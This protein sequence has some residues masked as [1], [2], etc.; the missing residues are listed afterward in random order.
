MALT[1]ESAVNSL[2]AMFPKWDKEILGSILISNNGRVESTIE[3]VLAME[4]N[5]DTNNQN[6]TEVDGITSEE[7]TNES[8][9]MSESERPAATSQSQMPV[10][11][12]RTSYRGTRCSLPNDFLLMPNSSKPIPRILSDE[13]LAVMLQNE[14]FQRELANEGYTRQKST[15]EGRFWPDFGTRTAGQGSGSSSS[16]Q[17]ATMPDL[18]IM[19]SIASL[20]ETAKRNLSNI[21]LRFS[22]TDNTTSQSGSRHELKPLVSDNDDDEDEI[23]S[24]QDASPVGH[25]LNGYK[26][27]WTNNPVVEG[28]KKSDE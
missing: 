9:K 4:G 18:G 21:A 14:L 15:G 17:P 5:N 10:S 28:A 20:S 22:S 8:N 16:S 27:N 25:V 23:I 12:T 26:D 19:K 24:F 2:S 3:M 13:E 1:F 7:L 11:S 6:D